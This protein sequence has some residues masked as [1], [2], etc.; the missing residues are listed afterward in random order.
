MAR[1]RRNFRDFRADLSKGQ[2]S[3]KADFLQELWPRV[4][5]VAVAVEGFLRAF[6]D[7]FGGVEVLSWVVHPFIITLAFYDAHWQSI[8]KLAVTV[9]GALTYLQLLVQGT[10]EARKEREGSTST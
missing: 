7:L 2:E 6:V 3:A 1:R 8:A 9:I 4:V 5:V 10:K